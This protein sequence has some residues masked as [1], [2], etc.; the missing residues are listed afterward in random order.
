MKSFVDHALEKMRDLIAGKDSQVGRLYSGNKAGKTETDCITFVS[1]VLAHAYEMTGRANVANE[2]RKRSKKGTDL[3]SYLVKGR[4]WRT[5]YW[6]PDVARPRDGNSEHP[7]S[8]KVAIDKKTYYDIP[9]SGFIVNYNPTPAPAGKT[10]TAKKTDTLRRFE[11]VK[12]AY[13][14]A[15]GGWHTFLYSK[16]KVYEVHWD[17]IGDGLYEIRDF[18]GYGWSSGAM[19]V[20]PRIDFRSDAK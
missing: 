11:D 4:Q 1:Q 19:V 8:Y 14:L 6:N 7:Y 12:F 16:G 20:P 5:H 13:G 18:S 15:K 10:A 2:V 9:L 17:G 3:A